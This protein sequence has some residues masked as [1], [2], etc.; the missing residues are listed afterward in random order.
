MVQ[1]DF[2]SRRIVLTRRDFGYAPEPASRPTDKIDK[3]IW[4]S[5][6]TLPD[7]VAIRTSNYHGT[8]IRQLHDVWGAWIELQ[9]KFDDPI[10]STMLDAGDDFQSAAYTAMTGFYRL[11][12]SALRS[13]LELI[14]I[15]SWAQMTG[16][17]AKYDSWRKG[18]VKLSFGEACDGLAVTTKRL[19]DFLRTT[20][21]DTL[22]DQKTPSTEGGFARQIF[23]GLSDFSHSRPGHTD[24]DVR[25]SNGPIYVK[26]AFEHVAWLYF[27]T[28]GICIVLLMLAVPQLAI[29]Q[30]VLDLFKD[31][32]R[33]R[34]KVTQAA[35]NE[36]FRS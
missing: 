17:R 22:F 19:G 3:R 15:G 24:G 27:E 7:D 14:A 2:R 35:F 1:S 11:S 5:I 18:E 20:I 13:A 9:S 33:I 31:T 23:G 34:S 32:N 12:V 8:T 21:S 26:S 16:N 4:A 25:E 36:L 28:F 6:T 30:S 10:L 29:S